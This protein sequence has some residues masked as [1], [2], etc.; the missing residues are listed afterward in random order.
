[1][2]P[3]FLKQA[4]SKD[5]KQL[6]LARRKAVKCK[7]LP[8]LSFYKQ[9]IFFIYEEA[10]PLIQFIQLFNKGNFWLVDVIFLFIQSAPFLDNRMNSSC[11]NNIG[12]IIDRDLSIVF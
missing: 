12:Q 6:F 3:V 9:L 10:F 1:M 2:S 5:N 7:F 8:A 11:C 4:F